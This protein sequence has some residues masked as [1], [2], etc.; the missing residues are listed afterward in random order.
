MIIAYLFFSIKRCFNCITNV[1][2]F[3]DVPK[4]ECSFPTCDPGRCIGDNCKQCNGGYIINQYAN[5]FCPKA[6]TPCLLC[7][8]DY[9]FECHSGD[10]N[11]CIPGT[12][13][14]T[15]CQYSGILCHVCPNSYYLGQYNYCYPCNQSA[16]VCA[17]G[18][19][20]VD[21]VPG[22]FN[23]SNFCVDDC[24]PGCAVC[25]SAT[26]CSS[27]ATGK[28]GNVCESTCVDTCSDGT[29]DKQSGKCKHDGM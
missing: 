20:C 22:K 9:Y 10:C 19:A 5:P 23:A 17:S 15:H 2:C 21:C 16:C 24:P 26:S 12:C 8:D 1:F 29:C 3:S 4:S 11:V 6:G 14:E 27:C 7:V 18:G 28:Y 25:T 13:N